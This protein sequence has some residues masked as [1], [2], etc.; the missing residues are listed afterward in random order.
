M[1]STSKSAGKVRRHRERQRAA[2]LR[3]VQFWV[4]DIRSEAF[5]AEARRQSR[6]IADSPHEAEDQAF[7]DS[8]SEPID[9]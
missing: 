6:L 8:I 3:L 1:A 2:G 7:I 9:P 5:K 4:P